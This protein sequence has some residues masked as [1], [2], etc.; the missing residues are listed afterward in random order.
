MID[1]E[2]FFKLSR[3]DQLLTLLDEV[4]KEGCEVE[5][6]TQGLY[7]NEETG[8][9]YNKLNADNEEDLQHLEYQVTKLKTMT[10]KS[11][12]FSLEGIKDLHKQIF[13]EVYPWAGQTRLMDI[14]KTEVVDDDISYMSEY[15]PWTE[16]DP[17]RGYGMLEKAI[18][19]M[20]KQ[21][22]SDIKEHRVDE[23]L[24]HINNIWVT[25]PF[26]DGNTRTCVM[27]CLDFGREELGIDFQLARLSEE[28]RRNMHKT[29]ANANCD[30]P[31][32]R[33]EY[34]DE[35]RRIIHKMAGDDEENYLYVEREIEYEKEKEEEIEI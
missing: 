8:C 35:L 33:E 29:F 20:V 24:E 14:Y 26:M 4:K 12:E 10:A 25:H 34:M 13:D 27:F 1:R 28:E 3:T 22:Y 30:I 6:I 16:I 15:A 2:M 21:E 7:K 18:D 5:Y 32:V 9:F 23:L 11:R 19:N 17:P 31:E